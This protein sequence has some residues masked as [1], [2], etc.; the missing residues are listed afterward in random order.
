M[1]IFK[2]DS[3]EKKAKI[4]AQNISNYSAVGTIK[5]KELVQFLGCTV[6]LKMYMLIYLEFKFFLLHIIDKLLSNKHGDSDRNVII[7]KTIDFTKETFCSL[8]DFKDVDFD[9]GQV[10]ESYF[11][12][13][14]YL[15]PRSAS[16][17][18]NEN[19]VAYYFSNRIIDIL[20]TEEVEG[21][22]NIAKNNTYDFLEALVTEFV[23]L[24][25]IKRHI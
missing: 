6:D 9:K 1:G 16:I 12:E 22:K 10:Y 19:S 5:F 7:N 21:Y 8:N 17:V 14:F 4:I 11:Q 24:D 15:Y 25:E 13:V 18:G 3:P 2:K 20:L 23:S